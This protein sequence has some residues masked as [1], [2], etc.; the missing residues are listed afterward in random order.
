MSPRRRGRRLLR[1]PQPPRGLDRN[2]DDRVEDELLPRGA[3]RPRRRDLAPAPPRPDDDRRRDRPARRGRQARRPRHADAG[4]SRRL[5]ASRAGRA[6]LRLTDAPGVERIPP[7]GSRENLCSSTFKEGEHLAP[8]TPVPTPGRIRARGSRRHTGLYI[9]RRSQGASRGQR[10][11][12]H[13]GHVLHTARPEQRARQ[14]HGAARR[15]DGRRG[16]AKQPARVTASTRRTDIKAALSAPQDSIK[17]AIQSLGGQVLADYQVAYNGIKVHI[18]LNQI[19]RLRTL[20]DVIGVHAIPN[21]ERSNAI[22]VPYIGVPTVWNG[23]NFIRGQNRKIAIIDTGIDYMHGNFRAPGT[24]ATAG[25]VRSGERRRHAAGEP[26]V[27]RPAAP[28]RSRAESTSSVTT[29]TRAGRG[30]AADSAAR[31]EP[32]R[33]QR[34]R[35]ARRRHRGRLRRAR[36]RQHVRR[37]LRHDDATRRR[38]ASSASARVSLPS[39]PLRRPRL[40]LRRLDERDRRRDRVGGR[41]RHGRHQHVARLVVRHGRRPVGG[42]RDNAAKAGVVVVTSAGNSGPSQYITGSPGT[43]TH[44][45]SIAANESTHGVPRLHADAADRAVADHGHQRQR[46]AGRRRTGRSTRSSRST[47]TPATTTV[48]ESLGCNVS[49]YPTPPNATSM[50][51]VVRGVCARVGKAIRASR[52][53]RGSGVVNNTDRAAAVRGADLLA[54]GHGRA[55][56]GHD[57]VHRRSRVLGLARRPR[58]AP[59]SAP[60]PARRRPST[61]SCSR[62]RTSRASPA[63]RPAA[64]GTETA[65]S[66]RTSPRPA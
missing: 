49:D 53:V 40:R 36:R 19:D 10:R 16:Q 6:G 24:V 34:S 17:P 8:E 65:S 18:A 55:V 42:R 22:S 62:T 57:P 44:V 50:A 9:G 33:L 37:S 45:V 61:T 26:G 46:R 38:P 66:S 29:T 21:H 54:P 23:P 12:H 35:L 63:S 52:P 3:R 7:G 51:V 28:R 56:H 31:P 14:R 39:Q 15:R 41:Q 1:V 11:G 30:A 47:T 4:R 58:T 5:I 60:R 32:A 48:D 27:L 43:G 20:P 25:R 2:R 64:R 13:S 59:G